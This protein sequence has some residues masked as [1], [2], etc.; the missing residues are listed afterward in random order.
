[1]DK[2]FKRQQQTASTTMTISAPIDHQLQLKPLENSNLY[3]RRAHSRENLLVD[4]NHDRYSA[5]YDELPAVLDDTT[6]SLGW[7]VSYDDHNT[8]SEVVFRNQR[9]NSADLLRLVCQVTKKL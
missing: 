8:S 1:M 9:K 6:S 5:N 4:G 3:Q 2:L 7:S